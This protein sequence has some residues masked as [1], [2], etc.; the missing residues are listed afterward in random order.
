MSS[1]KQFASLSPLLK[2]RSVA[3]IGASDDPTRIGG[4]PIAYML[5]QGFDGE[6]MPVNPN[7]SRVQGLAAY[8]SIAELTRVPEVALVAVP[9]ESVAD[10]VRQLA[11]AGVKGA[12]VFS[13][14]FAEL[15][16][17]GANRQAEIVAALRPSGMRLFGPNCLG[18]FNAGSGF[19]GTF[20]S[21]VESGWPSPG[22]V[23][24]A[25]QSGAYGTHIFCS[26]RARRLGLSS[27]ITTGNE[28][29]VD[30]G[31]A[32]GWLA[33]DDDTEVI[34]AYAEGIRNGSTFLKAL[35]IARRARK[36]IILMKV[37]SSALGGEAA[38]SHTASIAGDDRVF[39]AVIADYGVI[40]ARTTQELL[41]VTYVSTKRI[42]PR[43]NTLGVLTVSGGGGVLICDAA[44]AA[45]LP[46]PAMP[47]TA[48]AQLNALIP[49]A[50]TRNPVDCT[51][52]VLNEV[53]KLRRFA[54]LLVEEGSYSSII[55][56]FSQ[57][58]AARSVASQIREQLRG[59]MRQHPDRLFVLSVLAPP[60][61]LAEYDQDGFLVFEDPSH[62]V[63][64]LEAM[65]RLGEAFERQSSP[66]EFTSTA[67]ILPETSPS[68]P[69]AKRILATAGIPFAPE[70]LATTAD[71]AIDAA[72]RLGFPVVV[73]VASP[74]ITHKSDVGGV[75]LNVSSVSEVREAFARIVEIGKRL[76]SA[77]IEGALVA[78]QLTG[79][80][81]CI[82][83]IHVD[84][85]FGPIAMFGLGGIFV[86]ILNDVVFRKCPVD[87]RV[88][89]EMIKGIRGS[90]LLLGARGR[91]QLDIE[92]LSK[93]LSNLSQ[94]AV[95]AG[96]NL[97]SVE[98]NPVIVMAEGHGAFAV[99]AVLQVNSAAT[100]AR[101][102]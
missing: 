78:K 36:P 57:T 23:G 12:I 74:D 27:V 75:F 44:A 46:M 65:G 13:A 73:K 39:D 30:L 42:Y 76:P 4:R 77:T 40:R 47:P 14:G 95:S 68:E 41:D 94:I 45:N 6:I 2:P 102:S 8:R 84:P 98:L 58:G 85:T 60:E 90:A 96:P 35:E 97:A 22:R 20:T 56:F 71:E 18:V 64:A 83:G 100:S 82:V 43:V 72:N 28:A 70:H 99:D 38:Q 101:S 80:T 63:V 29:D 59:V 53:T 48:Q 11:A 88:A 5:S 1:R 86:E 37:G 10:V 7:R 69:V 55:F 92:Q 9:K 34:T 19:Y 25:S 87:E 66:V 16:A 67:I 61:V 79:G 15:D 31:E 93:I 33:E 32:I 49:F 21:S 81:E 91:K 24:I 50:A 3:I 26:A 54:E 62:A 89:Q 51:A 52:Q 17:D